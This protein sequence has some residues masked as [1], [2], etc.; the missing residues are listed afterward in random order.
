MGTW[1][2]V[3]FWISYVL[4]PGATFCLAQGGAQLVFDWH[5]HGLTLVDIPRSQRIGW[6]VTRHLLLSIAL[7]LGML[8]ILT[9][10]YLPVGFFAAGLWWLAAAAICV[11]SVWIWVRR[12]PEAGWGAILFAYAFALA[13]ST[14]AVFVLLL[15]LGRFYQPIEGAARFPLLET[16]VVVLNVVPDLF[17][18]LPAVCLDMRDLDALRGFRF[19]WHRPPHAEQAQPH[20]THEL[21]RR[22][23]PPPPPT[24]EVV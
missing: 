11:S 2:I 9:R 7:V 12:R 19:A 8:N 5:W 15:A 18:L 16:G 20:E 14:H 4:M 23:T 1:G 21:R 3:P 10:N 13:L 24:R 6:A 22:R 17:V